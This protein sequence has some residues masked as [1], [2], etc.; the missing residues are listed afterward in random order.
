MTL[1]FEN[2]QGRQ[3]PFRRSPLSPFPSALGE[4]AKM[5]NPNKK[6]KNKTFDIFFRSNMTLV[7]EHFFN[8]NI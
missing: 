2:S 5:E 3:P 4:S 7:N 8:L 6:N 1:S